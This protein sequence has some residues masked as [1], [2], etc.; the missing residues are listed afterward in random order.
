MRKKSK[1][2][3]CFLA[4]W[5]FFTSMPLGN[6][7]FAQQSESEWSETMSD[8]EQFVDRVTLWE[9]DGNEVEGEVSF[10]KQ[11]RLRYDMISPLQIKL[12]AT[13][14]CMPPY[15]EKEIEYLLLKI[16]D[17]FNIFTGNIEVKADDGSGNIVTVATVR[18]GSDGTPLFIVDKDLD[19]G[20]LLNGYFEIEVT[21]NEDK[22]GDAENYDFVLPQGGVLHADIIENRKLPP[23][24]S[25]EAAGYDPDNKILTWCITVQNAAKSMEDLYPLKFSD[26]IGYGQTY[27]EGSFQ[28]IMP[29]DL[30]PEEFDVVDN[31]LFWQ[32]SNMTEGATIQYIYQTKVD[33]MGLLGS[34]I[35]N[36]DINVTVKNTL[37]VAGADGDKIIDDITSS[38]SITERT[39]VSIVKSE[40]EI[41]QYDADEDTMQI[42]WTITVTNNGYDVDELTVYDFFQAGTSSVHLK[43]EP[44]CD[45]QPSLDGRGYDPSGGFNNGRQYQWSYHIGDVSGNIT[46][47]ITYTT[48]IEKYSEYLRRNN[49]T[50]P[51]NKVWYSFAYPVGD[52]MSPKEF[53]GAVM[54]VDAT[55][56]SADI[57][58]KAGVYDPA[59]H[60]VTWT[61]TVNPNRIEL[62]NARIT[63]RIPSGQK[64]VSSDVILSGDV[65]IITEVDKDNNIVTFY[66]G[67]DGLSGRSA[68]ITL[69]TELEQSESDK[70]A[71]NWSGGLENTVTLFADG[72]TQAGVSD[73]GEAPVNS[74]VIEKN[75][76]AF[77]YIDHT[78][79]IT[80]TINQNKMKL[81]GATV[82]D[83]LSDYGLTL[84]KEKGV[85]I[86]GFSLNEGTEA[87]RPSYSYDDNTLKIYP[88][89]VLTDKAVITFTAQATDQYM[90]EHRSKA[91]INFENAAVLVSDQYG[92]EVIAQDTV[93]MSNRPVVK[94][95]AINNRT[96]TITYTVEFNRTLTDL[97][98]GLVLTDTLP[99]GV[100]LKLPTVKMWLADIDDRTGAMTKSD[101]EAADCETKITVSGTDTVMQIFLPEGKQA[102]ILEYDVQIADKN[103][104]PFVNKVDVTGYAGDGV[105][106]NS[107]S[108]SSVQ[109]AGAHLENLIYVKVKKTDTSANPLAGA[110]FALKQGEEQILMGSTGEDGYLT[111]AGVAPNTEYCIVELQAPDGYVISSKEW[112][113]TTGSQRGEAYALE[114][115]FVNQEETADDT[116]SGGDH[117]S[118][119]G[120]DSENIKDTGSERDDRQE[121]DSKSGN[122]KESEGNNDDAVSGGDSG[123]TESNGDNGSDMMS[124]GDGR[125]TEQEEDGREPDSTEAVLPEQGEM[126]ELDKLP[127]T[128]GFWGSGLMYGIGAILTGIGAVMLYTFGK[129]TRG[130]GC[131]LLAAGVLLIAGTLSFRIYA[132]WR[133]AKEI[134][135]FEAELLMIDS[136][137]Y[138][139]AQ[140]F[141]QNGE[142]RKY[143]QRLVEKGANR[144][145]SKYVQNLPEDWQE[146][147]ISW[148]QPVMQQELLMTQSDD[149]VMAVLSIPS[150]SCK[151]IIKEGCSRRVLAKALGHMEGTALPGNSG[152]CVIAGHRNYSFGLHFNRLNEVTVGDEITIALKEELYNYTVIEIKVVEPEELWV[153]DQT[154][155]ARL[156]LITC[157]PIYIGSH[158][159]IV[160]AELTDSITMCEIN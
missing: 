63:D 35:T 62:P 1:L 42:M 123:K 153:L 77:H 96:G 7:V 54:D 39:P 85:Q 120:E 4:V 49:G 22:V 148:E 13:E 46:Y 57:I 65:E 126:P 36:D 56:V 43:E 83:K 21:I 147:E 19:M 151:D 139:A 88:K 86:D 133:N 50:P 125:D 105:E 81:T 104:A 48:V 103:K 80:I 17:D 26:I 74:V 9:I 55:Q 157:T 140:E 145:K 27:V 119:G 121:A 109:V 82:I 60:R 106:E 52:D 158:R 61:V 107:V 66:F 115:I 113:F 15:M 28:I 18:I 79:P 124:G 16:P 95:G 111:F 8:G 3:I 64:Y 12:N 33:V 131:I 2:L 24:V 59:T 44:T 135:A 37:S 136:E 38:K 129:K 67:E 134:A 40:G 101:R 68:L 6:F 137:K 90:Y 160:V 102:Y 31:S 114:G 89:E 51:R 32:C 122:G 141:P 138:K 71:N 20:S 155:D 58:D 34:D 70:W 127:K 92:E 29:D 118:N 128:G 11:Y 10:S 98:A 72:L 132:R 87:S 30:E 45:P 53:T 143:M 84:V 142:E 156:T 130:C 159:L 110:V 5:L 23:T 41:I 154:D 117:G 100:L 73:T 97:P 116:G 108:F 78:I 25:K 149:S 69:V 93:N 144:E 146:S 47:T 14:V 150:I 99:G 75:M 91:V 112:R 152:N 94:S 76:A